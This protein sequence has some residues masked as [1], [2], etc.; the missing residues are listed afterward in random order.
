[1]IT[2]GEVCIELYHRATTHELRA[3]KILEPVIRTLHAME[4]ALRSI[5]EWHYRVL[6]DRIERTIDPDPAIEEAGIRCGVA[7]S[8]EDAHVIGGIAKD[9]YSSP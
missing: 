7:C 8:T 3:A 9:A 6:G 2:L 1:M 5:G 4:Q